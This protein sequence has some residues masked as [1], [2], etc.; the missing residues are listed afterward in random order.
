MNDVWLHPDTRASLEAY[1]RKPTHGLLLTGAQGVG[2]KT[3]ATRIHQ[4]SDRPTS[5]LFI[6][7]DEK[8]T[9]G[10]DAI[11]K[12]YTQTRSTRRQEQLYV[13]L[14]DADA[15][16]TAAQNALLKLLEEPVEGVYFILTSHNP[17]RLLETIR[18][19]TAHIIIKKLSDQDSSDAL[20]AI[21][22][23]V[24]PQKAQQLLFIAQGR[25][26]E[27]H[28]LTHDEHYFEAAAT[29][30]RDARVMLGGSAYERVVLAY[31]YE[32]DRVKALELLDMTLALVRF[33]V[34]TRQ[35]TATLAQSELVERAITAL[36]Q[37][38]HVRTH[39][40]HLATS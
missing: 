17:G 25:P 7:P 31:K 5:L 34:F 33:S 27:L 12:L 8:G 20:R 15:M 36:R 9:I 35:D 6:E 28:R 19:R 30:V 16:S 22:P 24:S 1:R 10:I 3:I 38:G 39:L 32:K 2:L 4:S 23:D 29:L 18:S 37:N 14:D 26:A 11:H 13:I 21:A 40:L